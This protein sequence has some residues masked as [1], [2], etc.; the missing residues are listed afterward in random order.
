V[1]ER[2]KLRNDLLKLSF[3]ETVYPS[4]ANFL[5][6]KMK[7]AAGIYSNL[8]ERGIIVRDRSKVVLC[9]DCLRITVGTESEN[10]KLIEALYNL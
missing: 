9:D 6:T 10:K 4:D 2:E 3:T 7:N 5:L 8:V 1:V